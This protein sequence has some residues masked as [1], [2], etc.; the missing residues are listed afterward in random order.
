MDNISKKVMNK[1]KVE[2][3]LPESKFYSDIRKYSLWVPAI[4]ALLFGSFAVSIIFFF[5]KNND[6]DLICRSG[7]RYML[8][9]M[10]YFWIIF[11]LA[12]ITIGHYSY[13]KTTLGHRKKLSLIVG[14][15]LLFTFSFGYIL[16]LLDFPRYFQN[17]VRG[18]SFMHSVM[19]EQS[20]AWSHPEDGLL[21]GTIKIIENNK[22]VISDFEGKIWNIDISGALIRKHAS[23]IVGEQIKII[24]KSNTNNNFVA[25]EVRPWLGGMG[26]NIK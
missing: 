14:I 7:G 25:E 13:S 5:L 9:S 4:A 16:M 11:L 22:L 12:F 8:R 6:I 1:I 17:I 15:Y 19:F 24:G 3:I 10:P 23:I 21:S 26:Q 2:K 18:N 20:A